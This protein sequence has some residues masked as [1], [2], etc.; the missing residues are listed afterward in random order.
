M[1]GFDLGSKEDH[2]F[3]FDFEHSGK[4]DHLCLFRPGSDLFSIIKGDGQG[5]FNIPCNT[6]T[7]VALTF[8]GKSFAIDP[9]DM[10]A[11]PL[12]NDPAGLCMSSIGGGLSDKGSG[13]S[14]ARPPHAGAHTPTL[15][16]L[17]AAQQPRGRGEGSARPIV[18]D[19]TRA[20]ARILPTRW[21]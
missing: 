10:L 2:C 17:A 20:K 1:A 9:R 3:A 12:S 11:M 21:Y 8:G 7:Q 14:H 18:S 13:R 4:L 6:T 15:T 5:G 16:L 19:I